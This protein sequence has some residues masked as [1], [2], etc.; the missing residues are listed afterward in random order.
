MSRDSKGLL[1]YYSSADQFFKMSDEELGRFI[2]KELSWYMGNTDE[3]EFDDPRSDCMHSRIKEQAELR[4]YNAQKQ[5]ESRDK[6]KQ[7]EEANTDKSKWLNDIEKERG[8]S[9]YTAF[10]SGWREFF[11]DRDTAKGFVENEMIKRR[12]HIAI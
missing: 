9:A 11:P 12:K 7:K 6:K 4:G 10:E 3:P 2:K 8:G 5:K 1:L